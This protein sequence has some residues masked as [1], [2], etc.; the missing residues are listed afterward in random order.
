MSHAGSSSSLTPADAP[1]PRS[2]GRPTRYALALGIFLIAAAATVWLWDVFFVQ[3]PFAL[4][5]GAVMLTAWVASL[6]PALAVAIAGSLTTAALMSAPGR[7]QLLA[8]AVLL[9]VSMFMAYLI[10]HRSRDRLRAAAAREIAE[11]G[12]ARLE[13]VLQQMPLGVIIAEAPSGAVSMTNEAA[14]RILRQSFGD[15]GAVADYGDAR[16]IHANG[17]PYDPD[18]YPLARALRGEILND[19]EVECLSSDGGRMTLR[20]HAS[21]IRDRTGRIV[22]ALSTFTDVTDSRQAAHQREQSDRLAAIGRLAG[23]VAHDFNN[24]LT[25][26]VGN[27]ELALEHLPS[28]HPARPLVEETGRSADRAADLTRQLLAFSRR[29]LLR[30]QIL[31]VNAIVTGLVTMLRRLV[32]EDLDLQLH[33]APN[34]D[35]ISADKGQIEQI[36]TNLV[37]NARDAMPRGGRLTIET[38][39]V[40][41]DDAYVKQHVSGQPGPHVM[42]AVTDTGMG[43]SRATQAQIFDPFFTTKALG[44]GTGLGLATVYGIVKQSGGT[45]WVY[46][47]PGRGTIFKIYF[48]RGEAP[49]E[50]AAPQARVRAATR[51]SETILVVE[52]EDRVRLLVTE[53]LTRAGYTVLASADVAGALDWSQRYTG[54]IHL[55]LTD[56]VMPGQSGR[57][58][59]AQLVTARPGIQ[60]LYMSGYTGNAIAHHGIIESDASL[61][62]KPFTPEG[63]CQR[64]RELLDDAAARGRS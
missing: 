19:E 30:P 38:V 63:L 56:V 39:N 10:E 51:G 57:D 18:E 12:R 29:Q 41:L 35:R 23:G 17:R 13:S 14:V 58:L 50:P 27:S 62:D 59:A 55:L 15:R 25:V 11:T 52:D 49:A 48:P 8:P 34:L 64:V 4:F 54:T 42:L 26:I 46:S 53:V 16:A 6:G 37:V 31:D 2:R 47:E 43:M 5:F 1:L 33:L 22:S 24:L 21:P 3:V 28:D 45:I 20:V 61:I 7:A 32:G 40:E 60:V 44:H 9:A 36:L